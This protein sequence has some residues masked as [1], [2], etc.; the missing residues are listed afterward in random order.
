M[1]EAF[2]VAAKKNSMTRQKQQHK[3]RNLLL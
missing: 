3:G 2:S 1:L